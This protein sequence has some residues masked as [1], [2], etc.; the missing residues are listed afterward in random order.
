M[1]RRTGAI[2]GLYGLLGATI[3]VS[4]L[5]SLSSLWDGG[6][7]RGSVSGPRHGGLDHR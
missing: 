4:G 7:I 6:N 3:H 5:D 1:L 2:W